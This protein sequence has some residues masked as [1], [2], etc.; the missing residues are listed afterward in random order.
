MKRDDPGAFVRQLERQRYARKH[1]EAKGRLLFALEGAVLA[2]ESGAAM[3]PEDVQAIA[4][5]ARRFLSGRDAYLGEY[6][7]LKQRRVLSSDN[8]KREAAV[9]ELVRRRMAGAKFDNETLEEVAHRYDMTR[10]TL[11]REVRDR[12]SEMMLVEDDAGNVI[13][14]TLDDL[15]SYRRRMLKKLRD[16]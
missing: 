14:A 12:R 11:Q 5:A 4:E 16:R 9:Y 6:A 10:S 13:F 1:G 3:D 7:G 8:F 15:L 2:E